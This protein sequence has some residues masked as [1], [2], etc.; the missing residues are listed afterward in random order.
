MISNVIKTGLK[1]LLKQ[2]DKTLSAL[3]EET[4]VSYN[5]LHRIKQNKVSSITF[6]VIE[7]ICNNLGC[8]PND[9]IKIENN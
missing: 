2:K 5:T 1:E 4:G 3:A 8:T 6:D 7:K 9:L